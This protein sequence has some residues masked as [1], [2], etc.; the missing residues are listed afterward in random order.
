MIYCKYAYK[1][2][3]TNF[4]TKILKKRQNKTIMPDGW[5]WV[6]QELRRE[7]NGRGGYQTGREGVSDGR[8]RCCS[9]CERFKI[10]CILG[11]GNVLPSGMPRTLRGKTLIFT[12]D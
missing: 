11:R 2:T 6:C 8:R 5:I 4:L 10:G 1:K 12:N 9:G 3:K 7:F